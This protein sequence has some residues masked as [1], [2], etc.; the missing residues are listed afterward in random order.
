MKPV[1]P[2]LWYPKSFRPAGDWKVQHNTPK[3]VCTLAGGQESAKL[4]EG[5]GCA[6]SPAEEFAGPD[7]RVEMNQM[8]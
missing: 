3:G 7:P 2:A 6:G 4:V 1:L 8:G 5:V